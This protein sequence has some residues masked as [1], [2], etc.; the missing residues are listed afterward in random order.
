LALL[1]VHQPLEHHLAVGVDELREGA[2]RC[3]A[4]E[5]HAGEV[6]RAGELCSLVERELCLELHACRHCGAAK[7]RSAGQTNVGSA[8]RFG[9][10]L[11]EA[12]AA[13]APSHVGRRGKED[14]RG[15]ASE[16]GPE[17][18]TRRESH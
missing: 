10:G 15:G 5:D 14:R 3:F 2:A 1:H 7:L 13:A 18:N 8:G 9:D 4:K 12:L 6:S 11:D 17:K 16:G